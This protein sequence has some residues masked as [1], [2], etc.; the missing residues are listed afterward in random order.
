MQDNLIGINKFIA[1]VRLNSA[2]NLIENYFDLYSPTGYLENEA[3]KISVNLLRLQLPE[4]NFYTFGT[5]QQFPNQLIPVPSNFIPENKQFIVAIHKSLDRG[6]REALNQ[7]ARSYCKLRLERFFNESIKWNFKNLSPYND[8]EFIP[9]PDL[10]PDDLADSR[11][12]IEEPLGPPPELSEPFDYSSDSS[13]STKEMS[14]D[15][16]VSSGTSSTSSSSGSTCSTSST[17]SSSTSSSSTSSSSSDSSDS[18]ESTSESSQLTS[19][20]TS[21]SID[22]QLVADGWTESPFTDSLGRTKWFK[23]SDQNDTW[24]VI[25]NIAESFGGYIASIHSQE[26]NDYIRQLS[27]TV[28]GETGLIWIGYNLIFLGTPN[29]QFVWHD[30]SDVVYI[31]WDSGQPDNG[32]EHVE[33]VG[34]GK[35][36]DRGSALIHRG[37]MQVTSEDYTPPP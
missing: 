4:Y 15:S 20:S 23:L 12:P 9:L 34:N 8:F 25:A 33:M 2:I 19:E 31:N 27:N 29:E 6:S 11:C 35:W 32:S 22:D 5:E 1:V 17:S 10:V 16:S 7:L 24:T 14:T 3:V 37:M 28:Y 36:H 18:S 30:W 13:Q 21:S 26:E